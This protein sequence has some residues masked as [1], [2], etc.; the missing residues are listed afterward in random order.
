MKV[1]IG[2]KYKIINNDSHGFPIGSVVT[3]VD[4]FNNNLFTATGGSYGYGHFNQYIHLRH[5]Q[6]L[7]NNINKNITIL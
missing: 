5:I 4:I 7:I 1:K 2:N 6:P 3:I